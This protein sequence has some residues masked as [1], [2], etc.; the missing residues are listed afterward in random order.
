MQRINY[1]QHCAQCHPLSVQL[2]GTFKAPDQ[3]L[4]D[5]AV[6]KFNRTPA[7]HREP[8]VVRGVLRERLLAFIQEFPLAPGEPRDQL[9]EAHALGKRSSVG[10]P[11]TEVEWE[12]TRRR[13]RPLER[14]LFPGEQLPN[15]EALPF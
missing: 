9:I 11:P 6:E 14:L 4:L 12:W 13:L 3:A 7:P 8:M 15:T 2:A 10:R 5:K 1:E